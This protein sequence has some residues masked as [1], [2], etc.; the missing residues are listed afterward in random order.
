ME[1]TP[2]AAGP[3]WPSP[4]LCQNICP[5]TRPYQGIT[6]NSSSNPLSI[7]DVTIFI[8]G[9]FFADHMNTLRPDFN[10]E[11]NISIQ[12]HSCG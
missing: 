10:K 9:N 7:S 12:L 6:R 3:Q 8:F 4:R 2:N 1:G 11:E 5:Q